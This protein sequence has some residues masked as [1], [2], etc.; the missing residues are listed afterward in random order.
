MCMCSKCTKSCGAL[1]LLFGVLFLLVD[2]GYWNFFGLQWWTVLFLL[3][4]IGGLA[5]SKCPDCQAARIGKKK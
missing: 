1:L 4:G 5:S 3:A 2:L